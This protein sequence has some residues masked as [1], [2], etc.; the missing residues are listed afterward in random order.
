MRRAILLSGISGALVILYFLTARPMDRILLVQ[1]GR[2]VPIFQILF[3]VLVIV[4]FHPILGRVE[5]T[6]DRL[7]HGCAGTLV[8]NRVISISISLRRSC[9]LPKCRRAP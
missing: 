6:V 4:F 7:V 8:T 3:V 9:R 1:T 2:D 5:E